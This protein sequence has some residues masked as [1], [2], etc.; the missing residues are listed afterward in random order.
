M[1]ASSDSWARRRVFCVI[2]SGVVFI[3][4]SIGGCGSSERVFE[5]TPD[6]K[7][8]VIANKIGDPSKFVK[9]KAPSRPPR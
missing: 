3:S 8:A 6:A 9:P 5:Q 1:K 4:L 7:K 2:S